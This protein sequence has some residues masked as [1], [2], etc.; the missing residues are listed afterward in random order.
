MRAPG[1]LAIVGLLALTACGDDDGG[2]GGDVSSADE[3]YIDEAVS[4]FDPEEDAPLTEEDARCLTSSVVQ[5][6]GSERLRE[7]GIEPEDFSAGEQEFPPG[8]TDGEANDIVDRLEGCIDL[9]QLFVD[10]LSEDTELDAE[11]VDCLTEQFDDDFVRRL[12]VSIFTGDS[13]ALGEDSELSNE[14]FA[15]LG[16]CPGVLDAG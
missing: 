5:T 12:F 2:G 16:E 9:P 8:I 15:M 14:L 3:E 7:I 6:V 11:A 13:A 1:V 4:T 10:S